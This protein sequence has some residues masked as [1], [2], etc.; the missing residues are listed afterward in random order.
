FVL[1]F[2][3]FLLQIIHAEKKLQRLK[4]LLGELRVESENIDP[5]NLITQLQD[6]ITTNKYLVYTKLS[7]E[8]EQLRQTVG[9]LA[10]VSNMPA[11]DESDISSL[12]A[13]VYSSFF[14]SC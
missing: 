12:Q 11:I 1:A 6:E 5:S 8:I 2:N 4:D 3:Y 7:K 10:R 14:F 13:E 9:E